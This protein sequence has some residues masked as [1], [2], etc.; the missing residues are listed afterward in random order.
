MINLIT[1][2]KNTVDQEEVTNVTNILK[3]ISKKE[4]L[5]KRG[6]QLMTN[7]INAYNS[8]H[9]KNV[10]ELQHRHPNDSLPY[11]KKAYDDLQ[12]MK[13]IYEKQRRFEKHLLKLDK[14]TIRDLKREKR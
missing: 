11:I 14:K 13:H 6:L 3:E 1:G 12:K 10:P 2:R 8:R 4:G 9:K 7:H 5:L